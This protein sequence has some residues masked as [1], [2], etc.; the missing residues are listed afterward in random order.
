MYDKPQYIVYKL[1]TCPRLSVVIG[2]HRICSVI[3]LPFIFFRI[4][5]TTVN[6]LILPAVAGYVNLIFFT[7]SG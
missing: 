5:L 4:A 3:G 7:Y 1:H 6:L 2:Y